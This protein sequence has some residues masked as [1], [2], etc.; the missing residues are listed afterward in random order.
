MRRTKVATLA[1]AALRVSE[2]EFQ[3]TVIEYA[4][5]RGWLVYSVPDS[6]RATSR[7]YPD[8]TMV[9][10]GQIIF[11]ELKVLRGVVS[12][13]QRTWLDELSALSLDPSVYIWRPSGWPEIELVLA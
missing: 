8:L 10:D 6:R 1:D 4:E 7:G 2:R 11:A 9:R 3:R 13:A 12:K 5:A